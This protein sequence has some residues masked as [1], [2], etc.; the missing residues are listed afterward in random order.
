MDE[1]KEGVLETIA[2]AAKTSMDAAIEGVSSAATSIAEAVT[3]TPKK[4]QR[5]GRRST[6]NKAAASRSRTTTKRTKGEARDAQVHT[7][8]RREQGY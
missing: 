6:T 8:D 2:E 5:R 3:G 7:E 1:E 4:P